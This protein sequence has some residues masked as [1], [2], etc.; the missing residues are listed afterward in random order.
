MRWI[1]AF[2]LSL[3][4][5]IV[6]AQSELSFQGYVE[7]SGIPV[8]DS[9]DITIRIYSDPSAG[10]ELFTEVHPKVGVKDGLFSVLIGSQSS[11]DPTI[12]DG[13]RWLSIAVGDAG[14]PQITPRVKL[15]AAP[16][17]LNT[18]GLHV[19]GAG[20]I[21]VGTTTPQEFM[22]LIEPS[23]STALKL[24]GNG[25]IGPNGIIFE[26]DTPGQGVQLLWRTSPDELVLE[27]TSDGTGTDG[28]DMMI[29]RRAFS[30]FRFPGA[31]HFGDSGEG[32]TIHGN[33]FALALTPVQTVRLDGNTE[34][35]LLESGSSFTVCTSTVINC[36][37]EI[38]RVSE[39][40]YGSLVGGL[41]IAPL[42]FG[43]AA[44]PTTLYVVDAIDGNATTTNH[45]ALIDNASGGNS[46]DVLALRIGR[47]DAPE[48]TNAFISFKYNGEVGAGFIRG[49]GSGGIEMTSSGSDY[50]EYLPLSNPTDN[51]QPGDVV[52]VFSGTVSR[53]TA[54]ADHVMVVST[55]PIVVG[56]HVSVEEGDMS[57][58]A[59]IAFIGQAP[60]KVRGHV[61]AGDFLIPSGLEDGTAVGVDP[62]DIGPGQLSAVFGTAWEEVFGTGTS[63]VNAAIGIDQ[64][65]ASSVVIRA[66]HERQRRLEA[67]IDGILADVAELQQASVN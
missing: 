24:G 16:S 33:I 4:P 42:G 36:D 44:P 66:L 67:K 29:F 65:S 51:L 35:N 23:G 17:S 25:T 10:P 20:K 3:L 61:K 52:G 18:R 58:Y 12:L 39:A 60:V 53:R 14:A 1:H 9:T 59:L 56:N 47:T 48:T 8:T 2:L 49:N 6:F 50:A 11:L 38:F 22:H 19:D 30:D 41:R 15:T 64:A 34:V 21:G 45:V 46:A 57:G 37:S 5:S 27:R 26:D 28:E 43:L 62:L 7:E 13:D 31:V 32:G 40:G 55:A 54:G 63:K